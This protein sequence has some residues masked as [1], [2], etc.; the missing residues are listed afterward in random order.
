VSRLLPAILAVVLA[1]GCAST[2]PGD[3]VEHDPWEKHNRR[4]FRFNE[5]VDKAITKPIAKGYKKVV[6]GPVRKSVTNFSANLATPGSALNNF[7]QGKPAHG[8]QE[9]GRFVINSTFGIGGLFDV[10]S[11]GGIEKHSEDFGQT[12]AVWGVPPGPYVVIPFLG[13]RTLRGAAA[14]PLDTLADPLYHYEVTSVRDKV[15]ALR[16]IDLRSRLL[17]LEEMLADSQDPYVT[18]RE[19]YL[20]N[21][22][23]QIY[24]G[25]PPLEDDDDLYDEFLEDEDY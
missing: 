13:P 18:M 15:Y 11:Y 1:S 17:S 22:E 23:F 12:A 25:D 24:D 6:P 8:F 2:P 19:S 9:L 4:L 3:G 16:L 10:A 5:V 7:L 20:Q 21:R 14:V